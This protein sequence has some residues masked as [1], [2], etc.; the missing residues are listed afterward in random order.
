MH[1]MKIVGKSFVEN[2]STYGVLWLVGGCQKTWEWSAHDSK[3]PCMEE[4]HVLKLASKELD[5]QFKI[6]CDAGTVMKKCRLF[7][8]AGA[9][10]SNAFRG[11][12]VV[13]EASWTLFLW[14]VYPSFATLLRLSSSGLFSGDLGHVQS[15]VCGVIDSATTVQVTLCAVRSFAPQ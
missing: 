8:R 15:G 14:T 5:L 4:E 9:S 3:G 12:L 10:S 1:T 11:V 7:C 6:A 13:L 2:I